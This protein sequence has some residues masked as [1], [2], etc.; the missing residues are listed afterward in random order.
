MTARFLGGLATLKVVVD[1]APEEPAVL[2]L[3]RR[4]RL[5]VYDA[6]YLELA[7][8]AGFPLATLDKALI[9]A[10]AAEAVPLTD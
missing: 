4:H 2:G 3:A 9:A 10:A 7:K 1:D 8:R 5:T 6:A